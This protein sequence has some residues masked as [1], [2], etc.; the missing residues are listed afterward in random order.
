MVT[1]NQERDIWARFRPALQHAGGTLGQA[2]GQFAQLPGVRQTLGAL[3]AVQERGVNPFMSQV[4][5]GLPFAKD[6][7]RRWEAYRTPEGDISWSAVAQANPL[8]LGFR[9]VQGVAAENI[10]MFRE[11]R[12]GPQNTVKA[13]RLAQEEARI[14]SELGR[15]IG[16]RERRMIEETQ[17]A[18]PKHVRGG[19]QE[20]PWFFLPSAGAA[21]KASVA[22]RAGQTLSSA[23]RLGRAAPLARGGL[24]VAETA[25]KPVEVIERATERAITAPFRGAQSVA[26]PLVTPFT[27]GVARGARRTEGP[28]IGPLMPGQQRPSQV[29]FQRIGGEAEAQL[30][31]EL[32]DISPQ[33]RAIDPLTGEATGTP[34]ITPAPFSI[35]PGVIRRID[36]GREGIRQIGPVLPGQ[37]KAMMARRMEAPNVPQDLN[38]GIREP[39]QYEPIRFTGEIG[40]EM[41]TQQIRDDARR[42]FNQNEGLRNNI[43][44]AFELSDAKFYAPTK[45]HGD[46]GQLTPKQVFAEEFRVLRSPTKSQ[47][48]YRYAKNFRNMLGKTNRYPVDNAGNT[49]DKL[50]KTGGFDKIRRKLKFPGREGLKKAYE[51]VT[52]RYPALK[53]DALL[54]L[55]MNWHDSGEAYRVIADAK[56]RAQTMFSENY[57]SKRYINPV[58]KL[59][60]SLGSAT[61]EGGA[62][63]I[64]FQENWGAKLKAA[65]L[66]DFEA[67]RMIKANRLDELQKIYPTRVGISPKI[68]DQLI[69]SKKK[70]D[71]EIEPYRV[72]DKGDVI[73]DA[74]IKMT[75]EDIA[76]W[77]GS[78]EFNNFD[79][80]EA[81][82]FYRNIGET[83]VSRDARSVLKDGKLEIKK[84][85]GDKVGYTKE[86]YEVLVEYTEAQAD[87]YAQIREYYLDKGIISQAEFDSLSRHKWYSPIHYPGQRDLGGIPE[88]VAKSLGE[89][90]VKGRSVVDNGIRNLLDQLD[91]DS[92]EAK[93]WL[94]SNS[95][96]LLYDLIN[97][98]QRVARNDATKAMV[99]LSADEFGLVDVSENFVKYKIKIRDKNKQ[100][101]TKTLTRAELNRQF[102][103]EDYDQWGPAEPGQAT[104]K[105]K[106]KEPV[107]D[108]KTGEQ[109]I[110]A[111]GQEQFTEYD[112]VTTSAVEEV[113]EK[114]P[115]DDKLNTGYFSYM[116]AGDRKV[117]GQKF[118][119]DLPKTSDL[120]GRV[121]AKGIKG[122]DGKVIGRKGETISKSIYNKIKDDAVSVEGE[123]NP[124]P[125]LLWQSVNGRAGLANKGEKELSHTLKAANGFFKSIYTQQNPLFIVR[126]SF[127]D[128]LTVQLNAGVGMHKSAARIIQSLKNIKTQDDF[129]VDLQ[130][131]AGP[132]AMQTGWFPDVV[133]T[134]IVDGIKEAGHDATV[135]T[136]PKMARDL[137]RN[138]VIRKA[139][140]AIPTLGSASEQ[141]PRLAVFT[142]SLERSIGKKEVDRLRDLKRT[143]KEAYEF[144]RDVS[145]TP[146]FDAQGRRI[147][148]PRATGRGF[149]DSPALQK[150]AQNSTEVTLDFARGGE[151]MRKWNEYILFLNPAFEGAKLPFRAL[152]FDLSPV[153]R[154]NRNRR[155]ADDSLTEWGSWSDQTRKYARLGFG[156]RGLTG[157]SLDA[158]SGGPK[159]AAMRMGMAFSAYLMLQ[160]GH[161]KQF[162]Y[163]GTPMYYDIPSYIRYN[164]MIFMQDSDRDETGEYIIDPR[165]GRPTPKYLVFPHRLREWNL[166]FQS[167]TLLDEHTDK[168]VPMDKKKFFN[169]LISSGSPMGTNLFEAV[170]PEPA[171]V[172]GEELMGR[173]FFRDADI[174]SEEFQELPPE[175]QYNKYTSKTARNVAGFLDKAPFIP[176]AFDEVVA[177]PQ[178]LE[179]LY[180]NVF[181]Q[182]ATESLNFSDMVVNWMDELS[183]ADDDRPMKDKVKSYREDMDATERKEF[184]VSLTESEYEE[185]QKEL[186]EA[187]KKAPI[188][189]ALKRSYYPERGGGLRELARAE[190]EKAFPDIDPQQTYRAGV[191][192]SK[193]RQKLKFRQDKDDLA[194]A[195][196]SA[197]KK[198]D[199]L[200]PSEWKSSHSKKWSLYEYDLEQ[201]A[202][203]YPKSI[204]AQ[205]DEVRDAYYT[206]MYTAAGKMKDTRDGV[207]LLLA[208][209]YA[210]QSPD[211]DP[212]DTDWTAYFKTRDEYIQRVKDASEAA[213]DDIYDN[214]VRRMSANNTET[215]KAYYRA[216]KIIAPYWSVGKTVQELYPA[217]GPRPDLQRLWDKYLNANTT[218]KEHMRRTNS[219]IKDMVKRR[220]DQRK[221]MI[222]RDEYANNGIPVLE[223]ALV[224]WYGGDY[225]RS[226]ITLR[227]KLYHNQLY[228]R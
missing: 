135:V 63:F 65:G 203:R 75:D 21:R 44:E 7:D 140:R 170:I 103:K 162:E 205:P 217:L 85:A 36:P 30:A 156:E 68:Y 165:T 6:A 110:S 76:N 43:D 212:S 4:I 131:S 192:A 155:S 159:A 23:G 173:D 183:D 31:K 20:L 109:K 200:T 207:D 51:V 194:L 94:P 42:I 86:Q 38:R 134:K 146:V 168:E 199:K 167:A 219:T 58:T 138:D 185:F 59:Y 169:Y 24:R 2:F 221:R 166:L 193:D 174:V 190:T 121:L 144:Q 80:A 104:V 27:S 187:D 111:K 213:G 49:M 69:A 32:G 129:F 87:L 188:L 182:L 113:L 210:I 151:Q 130:Q 28:E 228:N 157:M 161:N 90:S 9:G 11:T 19:I 18:L 180:E 15:Q 220:S 16:P 152:G 14:E 92:V 81:S 82:G 119:V 97:A 56:G 125:Q 208:G 177:S 8:S 224:Y 127:I 176:D 37:Q 112:V 175:E 141:G 218:Q 154:P 91:K 114:V 73:S 108:K 226:P 143:S 84:G 206:A 216:M 137:L 17:Y 195:N 133:Q 149:K 54:R 158:V 67:D 160:N 128:S 50:A 223:S 132:T 41:S 191:Q 78:R 142:K 64:N 25:L 186:K 122:A 222:K 198:G 204:Y 48:G 189:D 123:V 13:L 197:N 105:A 215:E 163:D 57:L 53:N 61:Q 74:Y 70:Y 5:A 148:N 12:I 227:G 179:H 225:Y 202:E 120:I 201:L 1:P 93:G 172:L 52:E 95:D 116:D 66:T 150:A 153:I 40:E 184:M 211:Q 26:R 196:W 72:N 71:F 115:Y 22:A 171:M 107:I 96:P 89:K 124:V 39:V 139:K 60:R 47:M 77:K 136:S 62:M 101:K 99:E 126:N 3:S 83:D 181:G 118:D 35:A 164:A 33:Q 55:K 117:F 214:F 10:P 100:I 46:R 98:R 209:Y 29:R 106:Y 178:R 147:A 79:G 145:Y 88:G 45:K 34:Y 102:K